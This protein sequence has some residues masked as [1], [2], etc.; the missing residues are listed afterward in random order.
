MN[1][2]VTSV[3]QFLPFGSA[4]FWLR[5]NWNSKT[6]LE[7]KSTLATLLILKFHNYSFLVFGWI[8]KMTF[9][10]WIWGSIV[11][12]ILVTSLLIQLFFLSWKIP[13]LIS[14]S[15]LLL[16]Y[17]A[18]QAT[19]SEFP[20]RSRTADKSIQLTENQILEINDCLFVGN[21]SM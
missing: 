5:I 12:R 17:F 3:A 20:T 8:Q 2:I 9:E 10:P 19:F 4:G 11:L 16:F 1:D 7:W 18:L 13:K 21:S 15:I 6:K 14:Y